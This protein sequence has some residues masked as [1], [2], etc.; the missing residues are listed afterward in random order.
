MQE[1]IKRR[2]N[3]GN[4]CYHSVQNV[5]SSRLLS[6]NVE[7]RIHRSIILLVN[8]CGCGNNIEL[9]VFENRVLMRIFGPKMDEM[10]GGWRKLHKKELHN[11]YSLPSK[12]RMIKSRRM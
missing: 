10:V 2:L 12:I 3:S 8:L 1:E 4:V 7:I 9:R 11:M 5:L 6:N